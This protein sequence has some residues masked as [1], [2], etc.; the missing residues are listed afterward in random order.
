MNNKNKIDKIK[1]RLDTRML[2]VISIHSGVDDKLRLSNIDQFR[3]G[4][5]NILLWTDLAGRGIDIENLDLVVNYDLP[6]EPDAFLHRVG[7]TG[8]YGRKGVALSL[9]GE[10]DNEI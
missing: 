4:K 8:R 2:K 10:D 3:A 5:Y 1:Q 9:I 7:R 6:R